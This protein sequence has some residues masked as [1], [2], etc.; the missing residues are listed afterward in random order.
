[1]RTVQPLNRPIPAIPAIPLAERRNQQATSQ[2]TS[3]TSLTSSTSPTSSPSPS[4]FAFPH[5][6]STPIPT[7]IPT[8]TACHHVITSSSLQTQKKV[9]RGPQAH[10]TATSHFFHH[11]H[12]SS[13]HTPYRPQSTGQQDNRLHSS[14][15]HPNHSHSH[16]PPLPYSHTP[17]SPTWLTWTTLSRPSTTR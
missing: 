12:L 5:L 8:P 13:L 10:L 3:S 14:L 9:T 2:S 17:H 11:Q 6:R 7:P 15:T 1:M 16:T 4:P